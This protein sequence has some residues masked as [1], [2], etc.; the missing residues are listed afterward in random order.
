[1]RPAL[2][3]SSVRPRTICSGSGPTRRTRRDSRQDRRVP[4]PVRWNVV[5]PIKGTPSAKSRLGA[6]PEVVMA[7]ALDS[8]EAALGAARV[9]VVTSPE[10][11]QDF[12]AL[13]AEVV[14]DAGRRPGR[15]LSAR[16]RRSRFRTAAV[17]LGDVPALRSSELADALELATRHPLAFVPDAED[18]GTVLITALEPSRPFAGVRCELARG[19]PCRGLCRARGTRGLGP[20]AGCRHDRAARLDSRRISWSANPRSFASVAVFGVS[21]G[22]PQFGV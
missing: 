9:I 22:L 8:V 2:A 19:A 21:D 20:A 13:G 17:M 11:A 14:V 15:R 4:E 18:D 3:C 1:M 6:T 12:A 10:V 5:V 16:D 7:I